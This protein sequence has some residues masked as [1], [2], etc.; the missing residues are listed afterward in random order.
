MK[1]ILFF[2][3]FICL[4]IS[5]V[6]AQDLIYTVSGVFEN[7]K[8]SLDSIVLENLTNQTKIT[9]GDLPIQSDYQINVTKKVY[10]GTTGLSSVQDR[11]GFYLIKNL[12]GAITIGNLNKIPSNARISIYNTVGQN[13]YTKS[14]VFTNYITPV[15]IR[16]GVVGIYL[17]KIETTNETKTFKVLGQASNG[18]VSASSEG[19]IKT[20]NSLK[21]TTI[22]ETNDFSFQIGDSI[23]VSV[24]K[25]TF[26]AYPQK[27]SID[28]SKQVSFNLSVNTS[29]TTGVSNSYVS[30]SVN[31]SITGYNPATGE[32]QLSY[33]GEAPVYKLGDIIVIETDTAGYLRKVTS[34]TVANGKA[35]IETIPAYM[36]E[37]FTNNQ[38]KLN[39]KLMPPE[40]I[41]KSTSSLKDISKALTD[42]DGY[43]HPVKII[44]H[45]SA[46]K[47][48]TKSAII[49]NDEP[50]GDVRII[51]FNEDFSNTDI[52]GKADDDVHFYISDGHMKVT[53]DAVFEFEITN[54]G[55]LDQ[56]TKVKKGDLKSFMFY[57]D[58]KAEF[59]TKLALDLTKSFHK[60]ATAE[61][62]FNA[63]KVTAKFIVA[64]V[65]VWITFDCDI[66]KSYDINATA[67]LHS[68]WGFKSTHTVKSGGTY[69]RE[70]DTFT[71]IS[72]YEPSNV[73][74]PLN[75]NGEV[76]VTSHFEL[77]PR[78]E[79]MF[80]GFFGPFAEIAP[81]V[82]G[83]YN[84]KFQSQVTQNGTESF[85]GWNS[86][87]DLGLDV[88][89]GTQLS[90]LWGLFEKTFG[91]ETVNCFN[92][93]LW[94]SP[95]TVEATNTLPTEA[96]QSSK[97][98]V[99]VKVTDLLGNPVP[100]GIVYIE[101]NGSFNKQVLATG[102]NGEANFVWTLSNSV[103]AN[104]FTATLF[105]SD[106]VVISSVSKTITVKDISPIANQTGTFTDSRDGKTYKWV[107]IGDQT[108]MA[109]NLA[110]LPDVH[111]AAS[112]S[113]TEPLYYVY[114]Y[115]GNDVAI[116]KQQSN[117]TTY[118]VLY[119]WTAAKAACPPGWHLPI[120]AEWTILENYLIANGYNY[121]GTNTENKIAKSMAATTNWHNST[122]IGAIGNNLTLNNKSGFSALPG[123]ARSG[124]GFSAVGL[125]GGWWT[126]TDYS[127]DGAWIRWLLYDNSSVG[128]Y[129]SSAKKNGESVRCVK[130]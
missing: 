29:T 59:E 44:Y 9:F 25:N 68:D 69:D 129:G 58:S 56:D 84:A 66:Y 52:Y 18:S 47:K 23:R 14:S 79:I 37:V 3:I 97:I 85:L 117:Y 115:N 86:N 119:N 46:G 63:Q 114:D 130:D 106:K 39:T 108:W 26:Y 34:S 32:T 83:N 110:Y 77:Y 27:L 78:A 49:N 65:P 38:I 88:R 126:F 19:G 62:I 104:N 91:P 16:I 72:S 89:V 20:D 31:D 122:D 2:G 111:S 21:S 4:A 36:N 80:Y 93:T 75:I 101:G 76:D 24:Y 13:I 7:S 67:S 82:N 81:Y 35:T 102:L 96:D 12:P 41:L 90:F 109:E 57:L 116:A 103:G 5:S 105:N 118:G 92:Y 22:G 1:R 74:Y 10:W 50:V 95:T 94:K 87:I 100:L 73:I 55:D 48:I 54:K 30:L 43:I 124:I 64:G 128:Q 71:P 61:K 98:P 6:K 120:V 53:S 113:Y 107:K 121:D 28:Y 112:E 51:D 99:T 123:G 11:G 33:T 45:D 17:V 40:V 127:A 15:N 42:K 70:T 60:E 125:Q 8:T